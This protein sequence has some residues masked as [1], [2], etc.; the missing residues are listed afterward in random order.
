MTLSNS[1]RRLL[2][3][4]SRTFAAANAG[5]SAESN[6]VGNRDDIIVTATKVNQSTP[7]TASVH[8]TEPQAIVSR[9]IIED[10]VAPTADYAQ[11]ILL[12][13]GASLASNSGNAS[14]VAMPRSR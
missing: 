7:I 10:S 5:A 3:A 11:V 14:A 4:A 13:S 12:T 9:S 6:P 2:A 8:T 1:R